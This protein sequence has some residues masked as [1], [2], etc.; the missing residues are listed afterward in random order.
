MRKERKKIETRKKQ[1]KI[2]ETKSWLFEK[3]NKIDKPSTELGKE[4]T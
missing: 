3:L 1:E 2:N 4:M